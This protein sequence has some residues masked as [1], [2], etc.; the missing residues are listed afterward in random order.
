MNSFK[1]NHNRKTDYYLP[2][3]T[4]IVKIPRG[5]SDT[6]I[7]HIQT[8]LARPGGK[9][10]VDI[11]LSRDWDFGDQEVGNEEYRALIHAIPEI[12]SD[13]EWSN[14]ISINLG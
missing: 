8:K 3:G 6:Y 12:C 14:E 13:L 4:G 10:Y 9:S 1:K 7:G 5:D 11:K 2:K